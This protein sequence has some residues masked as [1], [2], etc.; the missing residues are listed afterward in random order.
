M[1]LV[2]MKK[3]KE[4]RENLVAFLH[5][6]EIAKI[7]ELLVDFDADKKSFYAVCDEV[8][9]QYQ[10]KKIS[11]KKASALFTMLA[12]CNK[13]LIKTRAVIMYDGEAV[14]TV[15][16]E[17]EHHDDV[18]FGYNTAAENINA[19]RDR[20][21]LNGKWG[22]ISR[23]KKAF[24]KVRYTTPSATLLNPNHNNYEFLILK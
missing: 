9:A 2:E 16:T 22:Y 20:N 19:D 21:L 12:E 4:S 17:L 14:A 5:H 8:I 1:K 23:S 11:N 13:N 18:M 6:S 7:N 15:K 10:A 24:S 3:I